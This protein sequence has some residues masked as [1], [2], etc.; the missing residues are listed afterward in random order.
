VPALGG[1]VVTVTTS[2]DAYDD[3][4]SA[5]RNHAEDL[6]GWLGIWENRSEPDAHARRCAN[7]AVD[8]IDAM[9]RDLYKVRQQLIS[10]IRDSDD[11]SAARADALLA[12]TREGGE[13]T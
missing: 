8:A 12:R 11:A 9:L 3:A 5:I 4:L 13:H 6:G 10:E 2:Q 7:D 1:A